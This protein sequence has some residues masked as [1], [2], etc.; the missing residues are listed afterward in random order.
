MS[1]FLNELIGKP[2]HF[3]DEK[4]PGAPVVISSRIRIARNIRN[5]PF[6]PAFDKSQASAVA[7]LVRQAVERSGALAKGYWRL[8]VPALNNI[9]KAVLLE[10]HLA[11]S[12]LLN[13]SLVPE[14]FIAKDRT[15]S[16]MVNEE[17]HLRLQALMPGFQLSKCY[18][19]VSTL[20]DQLSGEL[21]MAYDAALG[22]LTAC[23]SNVGTA[24]RVS[25][26]LHLPALAMNGDIKQLERGLAKLGLTVRGMFGE[27]TENLGNFFQI[28]NQS[29]LGESEEEIIANLARVID[30]VIDHEENMRSQLLEHRRNYLLDAVG[31]SYGMLKYSYLL[32]SKE[33][34]RALSLVRLGVDMDM[35][36]TLDTPE[37]NELFININ[38]GHLQHR[39]G[40]AL[41][42]A[43]E[44]AY[45]AQL[46][47]E[48]FK[49]NNAG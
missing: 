42:E 46:V 28:S 41:A 44:N 15:C 17:D 29:T 6:P 8:D 35:F 30:Q 12:E 11:S 2:V 3:L 47:R 38:S 10:R 40:R 31:R 1:D 48:N 18:N 19:A 26:M 49:H 4:A 20:D 33:A 45:R 24:I 39:A 14:L 25:V 16:V 21:D 9:E 27:G 22:Y 32:N 37:I 13:G 36:S 43:E 7:E 5:F 23:P 34:F